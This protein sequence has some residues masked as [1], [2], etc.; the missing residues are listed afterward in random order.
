VAVA[1]TEHTGS[2]DVFKTHGEE[3]RRFRSKSSIRRHGKGDKKS[4]VSLDNGL[5]L[6]ASFLPVF[7]CFQIRSSSTLGIGLAT[8]QGG[9]A[10]EASNRSVD[11]NRTILRQA[12]KGRN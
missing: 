5:N 8:I 10:K 12:P 7:S 3:F 6:R 4:A 1:H 2:L 11:E 9:L